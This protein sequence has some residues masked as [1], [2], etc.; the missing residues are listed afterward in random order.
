VDKTEEQRLFDEERIEKSGK[1]TAK[2]LEE[3]VHRIRETRGP[4]PEEEKDKRLYEMEEAVVWI[5]IVSFLG[6]MTVR[7]VMDL[8][9]KGV[10]EADVLEQITESLI[11][12]YNTFENKDISKEPA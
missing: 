9:I 6:A 5:E 1:R 11:I 2:L 3:I 4:E 12:V 8:K 10:N 7:D